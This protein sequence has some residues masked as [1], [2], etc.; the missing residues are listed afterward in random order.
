MKN[1]AYSLRATMETAAIK[2]RS[3][4]NK[5][6]KTEV[7]LLATVE[8]LLQ[9]LSTKRQVIQEVSQSSLDNKQQQPVRMVM[10]EDKRFQPLE[11]EEEKEGEEDYGFFCYVFGYTDSE[12]DDKSLSNITESTLTCTF[13][14]E[15]DDLSFQSGQQQ[16]KEEEDQ[17]ENRVVS[18]ISDLV[19]G[20]K[21]SR[22]SK[23]TT[24]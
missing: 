3:M 4:M 14:K 7:S 23:G 21:Q 15:D 19:L 13:G 10:T 24:I 5:I 20:S 2:E 18:C 9:V 22:I 12:H 8:Q 17:K 16:E 11:G 6:N 1:N